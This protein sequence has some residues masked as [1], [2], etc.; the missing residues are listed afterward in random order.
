MNMYIIKQ[1]SKKYDLLHLS[2]KEK[3]STA[4]NA[5]ATQ[6]HDILLW[7]L[8]E[9]SIWTTR[10]LHSLQWKRDSVILSAIL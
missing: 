4:K 10:E 1:K 5:T 7:I 8:A 3:L 2:F 6:I 9:L